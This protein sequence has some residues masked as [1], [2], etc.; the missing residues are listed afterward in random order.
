MLSLVSR[1]HML[2]QV[3]GIRI[4]I[5]IL[6]FVFRLDAVTWDDTI[7][8]GLTF[9]EDHVLQV[10]LFLMTLMRYMTPTLD[11]MCVKTG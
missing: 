6:S 1:A 4:L 9:I 5:W 3:I 11:D 10:P 7:I 2:N 8:N